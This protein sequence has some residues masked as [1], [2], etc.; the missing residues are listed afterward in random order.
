[1]KRAPHAQPAFALAISAAWLAIFGVA[2]ALLTRGF[3]LW[4]FEEVRRQQ[5]LE[6]RLMAPEM[7][8]ETST[9][10]R[11]SVFTTEAADAETVYLIDF[12]YTRCESV[13]SVLG[14]EFFQLQE[15]IRASRANIRLLSLSI[16]P[17]WDD[18]AAL[19]GYG[20]I[21]RA[22]ASRWT[23]ARPLSAAALDELKDRLGL[24]VIPDGRG[25]FVHN[26]AI[27]LVDAQR[28]VS[29]IYDYTDWRRA[30]AHAESLAGRHP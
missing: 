9:G 15:R 25:G 22:D 6:S 30:L 18:A 28:R 29:A 17:G 7:F 8:V 24:I 26:G 21:H 16:D 2:A 3:H 10:A 12:I 4:T 14:A 11:A 5:A 27:H 23:L 20:R 19:S 13:C 1:M